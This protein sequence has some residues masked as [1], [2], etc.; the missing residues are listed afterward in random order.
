MRRSRTRFVR[1]SQIAA[2]LE[3]PHIVPIYD[4]GEADGLPYIAMRHIDGPDLSVLLSQGS[5]TRRDRLADRR[6]AGHRP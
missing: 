6:R 4:A 1:E 2:A 5:M 3:H